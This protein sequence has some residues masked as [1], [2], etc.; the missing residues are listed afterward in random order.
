MEDQ[1]F[2]IFRLVNSPPCEVFNWLEEN[3][4]T[5]KKSIFDTDREE[6]EKALIARNE[7]LINLGLALFGFEG[8]T[9]IT[10][11]QIE[12]KIIKKAVLAGT[13]VGSK[14]G[15]SWIE[16]SGEL[17]SLLDKFDEELLV[18]LISNENI[19]DSLLST[20]ISK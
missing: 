18:P 8:N 4:A 15:D 6:L 10:L 19:K 12:D 14:L 7:P 11:F 20:V 13:T 2:Q 9:G 5:K 3:K 17:N 16:R 1:S